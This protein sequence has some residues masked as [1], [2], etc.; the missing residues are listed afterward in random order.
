M[1]LVI[2]ILHLLLCSVSPLNSIE[3]R[4]MF[5][6]LFY[7]KQTMMEWE[8]RRRIEWGSWRVLPNRGKTK[9]DRLVRMGPEGKKVYGSRIDWEDTVSYDSEWWR[10]HPSAD[11]SFSLI[12]S[13][14]HTLVFI[15]LFTCLCFMCTSVTRCTGWLCFFHSL[16][17]LDTSCLSLL[18][19]LSI[20]FS[21]GLN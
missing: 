5:N 18:S 4:S 16:V 1:S 7:Y 2:F 12:L 3:S 8:E 10:R 6:S 17:T 15:D 14:N 19:P 13:W 9:W 11:P 21:S 20:S